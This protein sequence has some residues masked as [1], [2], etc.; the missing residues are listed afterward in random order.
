MLGLS[1]NK[2]RITF[3][4]WRYQTLL[5]WA[6]HHLV[7]LLLY[8]VIQ[9]AEEIYIV[10]GDV[11]ILMELIGD[12]RTIAGMPNIAKENICG[13]IIHT[14]PGVVV[15]LM[16][17]TP[18]GIRIVAEYP[19]EVHLKVLVHGDVVIKMEQT[20]VGDSIVAEYHKAMN[21]QLRVSGVVVNEMAQTLVGVNFVELVMKKEIPWS[22]Y[23]QRSGVNTAEI[24]IGMIQDMG[25]VPEVQRQEFTMVKIIL[26]IPPKQKQCFAQ[27]DVTNVTLK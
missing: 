27:K 12:G 20:P 23:T 8:V 5:S 18:G 21:T 2:I 17:Q 24:T 25:I 16:E 13:I 14:V 11:V 6:D 26:V 15:S 22:K 10:F 19:K 9:V 4:L 3:F 1:M 7:L